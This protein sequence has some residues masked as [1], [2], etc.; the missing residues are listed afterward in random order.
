MTTKRRVGLPPGFNLAGWIRRGVWRNAFH[1]VGGFRVTGSAPYEAMVVVANHSSHTDTPALLAAIPAQYKPVVVAAGDYWFDK[2]W[3]AFALKLAIGAVP[4]RRHGGHGYETL[5]EGARQVLGSGSSLLVFP[6]GGRSTDGQIGQFHTGPLHLA[7][8]FDVPVLPVA[9]VG[10]SRLLP[11]HGPFRPGPVEVRVGEAIQPEDLDANDTELLRR[12][13]MAM[14]DQGPARPATSRA[15]LRLKQLMDS[16]AG[17]LGAAAWGFAEATSSPLTQEVYLATVALASPRQMPKAIVCLTAGSAAGALVNALLTRAGH[18][19][20]TLLVTNWMR[21]TAGE[22]LA[23]GVRGLWRQVA[24]GIPVK[25]Y[26]AKAGD[27]GVPLGRFVLAVA[28]TRATRAAGIGGLA[29]LA[30]SRTK[31]I[32]RRAYGPYLGVFAVNYSL[33]LWL[34]WRRWKKSKP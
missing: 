12:Q 2:K 24:N 22:H 32:L 28:A 13:I 7:K 31:P 20:P 3:K 4:V 10:T 25:V 9:V 8:E 29:A 6:E 23:G 18:R 27:M 16:K 5:V 21:Q 15:W 11:K 33:G 1:L 34:V 14:L 26:A 17:L 30:A 19:P